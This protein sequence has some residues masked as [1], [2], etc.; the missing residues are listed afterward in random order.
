MQYRRLS[1]FAALGSLALGAL[2]PVRAAVPD[3]VYQ[4]LD[5]RVKILERL[6]ELDQEAAAAK[7]KDTPVVTANSKDGFTIKSPDGSFKLKIGGYSQGDGRFWL[8]DTLKARTNTF[9]LR[10]V[11]PQFDGTVGKY[12]DFRIMPDFGGGTTVL[13]DAY[14]NLTY[15]PGFKVQVGKFKPPIGLERLQSGAAL[16]FVERG[17]PTSLVPNRDLGLQVHG[18]LS[19]GRLSY[20]VGV[21]N[22]V[23][24]GG[25][26]DTDVDDSKELAARIFAQPFKQGT[27]LLQGLS[28][29]VAGSWGNSSGALPSFRTPGQV[30]FFTYTDTTVANGSRVRIAPQFTYYTGPLGLLGEYTLSKQELTRKTDS[31]TLQNSAWQVAA[32]YLLSGDQA[33]YK[34]VSPKKSFDPAKGQWGAL[35]LAA[36]FHQLA[37]DKDA[38]PIFANAK[39]S[40]RSATAWALGINWYLH[41][42][43]KLNLDYEQTQFKGGG[44]KG[45][46]D[47]EKILFNR[48][49]VSF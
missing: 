22:G 10:R 13:Y 21:F 38:Y 24:D 46:R 34:G 48:F 16:L 25:N 26:A 39:R 18:D 40:A 5:Q 47:A 11:R 6:H 31:A 8:G 29:G 17:L 37:I 14:L 7:A 15:R 42:N 33:G 27:S 23:V 12:V 44:A 30:S 9:F 19:G 49:Q 1:L 43:T 35:E 36:R 41:R 45:D 4:A 28:L 32:S 3:S 20:A 2:Q